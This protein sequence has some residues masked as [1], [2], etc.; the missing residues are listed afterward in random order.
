MMDYAGSALIG[1]AVKSLAKAD[2]SC[3]GCICLIAGCSLQ[4]AWHTI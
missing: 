3:T 1:A 4:W 2:R